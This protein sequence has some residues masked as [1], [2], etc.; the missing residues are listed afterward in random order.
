MKTTS[1]VKGSGVLLNSA[2]LPEG[3]MDKKKIDKKSNFWSNLFKI[4][5]DKSE[6]INLLT[7]IPL[8]KD[9]SPK[10]LEI[11]LHI[12]HNRVYS[13]GEFIFYQGD[14]GIAL[15]IVHEGE[16]VLETVQ[17]K[18]AA[19]IVAR[20]KKGDFFGELAMLENEV[21]FAS[22]IAVGEAKLAVIFKPDLDEYVEKYPKKGIRILRGMSQIFAERL[23]TLN[24]EFVAVYNNNIK[25]NE[26]EVK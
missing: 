1:L 3:I 22:A 15:Y 5:S 7:S 23:R 17:D 2:F 13:A 8:F 16:V 19:H 14:P 18:K 21:R 25:A 10:D 20:Y 26:P 9:L 4:P 6:I 24:Q 11:L 12:M